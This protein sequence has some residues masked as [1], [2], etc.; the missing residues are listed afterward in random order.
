MEKATEFCKGDSVKMLGHD[1]IGEVVDVSDHYAT[2]AFH[3]MEVNI[4]FARLEKARLLAEVETSMHA[5]QPNTY[6]LNAD[7]DA[8][9]TFN[10]EIDLHGMSISKAL[11]TL[12]TWIDKAYLLGY[13]QLK[14][15]HGK[16]AGV[17]R[18]AVRNYLQ[19][20]DQ[21]RRVITQHPYPGGEGVTWI[22]V[23]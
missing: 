5:L 15:I 21:V 7:T 19:A 14:I 1:G 20:H 11:A 10:T 6:L 2:V 22:E 12:T 13:K 17:L 9:T 4:P 16:G 3:A 23:H 8:L 18:N